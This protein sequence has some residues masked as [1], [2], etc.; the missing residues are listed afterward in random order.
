MRN[1]FSQEFR[2]GASFSRSLVSFIQEFSA[3]QQDAS[4]PCLAGRS[5]SPSFSELSQAFSD[6]TNLNQSTS[7]LN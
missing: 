7:K 6:T 1:S 4:L 5:F 3:E 2:Y